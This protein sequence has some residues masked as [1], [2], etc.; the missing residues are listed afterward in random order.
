MF[1]DLSLSGFICEHVPKTLIQHFDTFCTTTPRSSLVAFVA[2]TSLVDL[3]DYMF[4]HVIYTSREHKATPILP[5]MKGFR[6]KPL[7]NRAVV[8]QIEPNGFKFHMTQGC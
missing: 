7:W 4:Y 8:Q 2:A 1:S 3:W 6:P 5:T